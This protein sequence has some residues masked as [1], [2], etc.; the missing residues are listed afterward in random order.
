MLYSA[1]PTASAA[2][3]GHANAFGHIK[4][5]LDEGRDVSI[6]NWADSLS[7]SGQNPREWIFRVADLIATHHSNPNV[8]IATWNGDGAFSPPVTEARGTGPA[9]TIRNFAVPGAPLHYAMGRLWAGSSELAWDTPDVLMLCH[10]HNHVVGTTIEMVAG[11]LLAAIEYFR[12]AHPGVPIA[13][14]IQNPQGS[15]DAMATAFGAWKR[16]EQ[17]RDVT[18]IDGYSPWIAAGKPLDWYTEKG[19]ARGVI[20]GKTLTVSEWLA[21]PGQSIAVGDC[22]GGADPDTCVTGL[23]SG[24]GGAGTYTVNRSQDRPDTRLKLYDS[25]HPSDTGIEHGFVPALRAAWGDASLRPCA[26]PVS[27]LSPILDPALNL[28]FNG[29]FAS[30]DDPLDLPDGWLPQGPVSVKREEAIRRSPRN[31][32]AASVLGAEGGC[33]IYQDVNDYAQMRGRP[34]SLLAWVYRPA[35]AP[36]SVGRIQIRAAAPQGETVIATT[37]S[38]ALNQADCWVP[39]CISGLMVPA[40]ATAIRVTLFHD[41]AANPASQPALFQSVSLV[42]G[43]LPR[44]LTG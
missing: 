39:W 7:N 18:L 32:Y 33:A 16:L 40:D 9:V 36:G 29:D 23:G 24:R 10:G 26:G 35:G 37:R 11:E 3:G 13:A 4:W 25:I 44:G 38:Y 22:I 19:V 15:N 14:L 17:L 8:E 27:S 34:V 42:P 41:S 43:Y 21:Q 12:L 6:Y 31:G 2:T 28:L 1:F 20:T 5:L 30:W